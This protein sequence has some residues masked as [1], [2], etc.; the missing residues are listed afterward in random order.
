MPNCS[1]TS[2]CSESGTEGFRT[3]MII[4]SLS[5][6]KDASFVALRS[7]VESFRGLPS[8]PLRFSPPIP[9]MCGTP[10]LN[11]GDRFRAG[12]MIVGLCA[13][14]FIGLASTRFLAGC[15]PVIALFLHVL[16]RWQKS[17]LAVVALPLPASFHPQKLE[18]QSR[19]ARRRKVR[20]K[21]CICQE[22]EMYLKVRGRKCEEYPLSNR[23]E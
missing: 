23:H 12:V 5:G 2:A 4:P 8:V 16:R 3:C 7:C 18:T 17:L 21:R 19:Q 6:K 1:K 9:R 13:P 14:A 10:C 15:C 11:M 20:K 22:E